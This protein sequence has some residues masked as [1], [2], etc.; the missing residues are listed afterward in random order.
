MSVRVGAFRSGW[1]SISGDCTAGW[2]LRAPLGLVSVK[3]NLHKSLI[4]V[5]VPD[6][7]PL[8]FK[9]VSQPPSGGPQCVFFRVRVRERK[10]PL[11]S[12]RG[13]F[14]LTKWRVDCMLGLTSA[15]TPGEV[16]VYDESVGVKIWRK[17]VVLHAALMAHGESSPDASSDRLHLE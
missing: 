6:V 12:S 14:I 9:S 8:T 5:E 3:R 2:L 7:T 15:D 1:F 16:T 10:S 11:A 13:D 17:G 4:G